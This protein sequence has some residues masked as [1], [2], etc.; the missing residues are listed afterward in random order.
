MDM[1]L[2]SCNVY[3]KVQYL[4]YVFIHITYTYLILIICCI[5]C[6]AVSR[7]CYNV[8]LCATVKHGNMLR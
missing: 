7:H 1:W 4:L 5:C 2:Y 3:N 6:I 8:T